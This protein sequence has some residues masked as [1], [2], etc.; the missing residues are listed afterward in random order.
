M[1]AGP[2]FATLLREYRLAAGLTQEDLADRSRMSVSA[3]GTLERGTHNAPQR[4]T[5]ELLATALQLS[6]EARAE[7]ESVAARGRARKQRSKE[8]EGSGGHAARGLPLY[9]TSFV[10]RETE[11]ADARGTLREH[12]LLTVTGAGG[13]G[14]TRLAA[15]IAAEFAPERVNFVELGRVTNPKVLA[16]Q[17]AAAL[18]MPAQTDNAQDRIV[19][20]LASEPA[21]LVLDNCEHIVDAVAPL[22]LALLRAVPALRILATSRER[23]RV[24]GEHLLRL[25]PLA[26]EA[27]LQLFVERAQALDPHFALEGTFVQAATD[28]CR[29]LDGIPLAIELAVAR[30]PHLGLLEL[31]RQLDRQLALPGSNRDTP[32]RHQTMQ[33]TIAWSFNLLND[34]E[35]GLL[36]TLAVFVG[37]F[38]LRAAEIVCSSDLLPA[39]AVEVVLA[40]LIDKSMLQVTSGGDTA[41]YRLLDSV[42]AYAVDQLTAEGRYDEAQGRHLD[43]IVGLAEAAHEELLADSDLVVSLTA[44]D[45]LDNVR[46]A[47]NRLTGVRDHAAAVTAARIVGGLR[48]TW[49]SYGHLAEA[50][51]FV[52]LIEADLDAER[53]SEV[54]GRLIRI[55]TQATRGEEQ[56]VALADAIAFFRK[57]DDRHALALSYAH[58]LHLLVEWNDV[59]AVPAAVDEARAF[60]AFGP[61]LPAPLHVRFFANIARCEAIVDN[62]T[63]A[64]DD[65]AIAFTPVVSPNSPVHA[66]RLFMAAEV[67]ALA[68]NYA[69]ASTLSDQALANGSLIG[70]AQQFGGRM[71]GAQYRLLAGDLEGSARALLE[72]VDLLDDG[73]NDIEVP[74]LNEVVA[75]AAV[76]AAERGFFDESATLKGYVDTSNAIVH[77][78]PL[79]K[80]LLE[81]LEEA[82]TTNIDPATYEALRRTGAQL[83]NADATARA[84]S[85]V[86]FSS[87]GS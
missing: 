57:V 53:D 66:W 61:K 44:R 25:Q 80:S 30:L 10:G 29:R 42:R 50:L 40:R 58:L 36:L 18:G 39:D 74:I 81:R 14:K 43:W 64:R 49:L 37:G 22:A 28:M 7:L 26:P 15:A 84:L 63:R 83:T 4:H 77:I 45:D 67:E 60:F 46:A 62:F 71:R 20:H 78:G 86:I 31:Q 65:V 6:P 48:A 38:S 33:T 41:R 87:A 21:L 72:I 13:T 69:Q 85:I 54:Y 52:R 12:R 79:G 23:L 3:I 51:R 34:R 8:A 55:K 56:R 2:A 82:L 73:Y 70:Q 17:I 5:V 24:N 27:A 11:L 9:L 35:R 32:D 47:V 16:L 76:I 68:G 75:V 19:E 59:D 1:H